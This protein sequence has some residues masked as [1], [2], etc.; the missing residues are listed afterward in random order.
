MNIGNIIRKKRI[1]IIMEVLTVWKVHIAKNQS[2]QVQVNWLKVNYLV[3]YQKK[4]GNKEMIK[5]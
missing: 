1:E 2:I 3:L 4:Q 5:H